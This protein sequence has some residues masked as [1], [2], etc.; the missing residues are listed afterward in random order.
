LLGFDYNLF[1][2]GLRWGD[3]ERGSRGDGEQ[4][5]RGDGVIKKITTHH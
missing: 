1:I 5:S 4:G 2:L 3:G